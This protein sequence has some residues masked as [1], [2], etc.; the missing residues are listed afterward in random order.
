MFK[1]KKV[2]VSGYVSYFWTQT[3][4]LGP[5]SWTKIRRYIPKNATKKILNSRATDTELKSN[6]FNIGENIKFYNVGKNSGEVQAKT[7]TGDFY[8]NSFTPGFEESD[9]ISDKLLNDIM[10]SLKDYNLKNKIIFLD[11][12]KSGSLGFSLKHEIKN[13]IYLFG[14]KEADITKYR[15]GELNVE[16]KLLSKSNY[17]FFGKIIL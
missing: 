9:F 7:Y 4:R 12:K 2:S 17:F 14:T 10:E 13:N 3:K 5:H 1:E 6:L 16:K 11:L 15:V 8:L